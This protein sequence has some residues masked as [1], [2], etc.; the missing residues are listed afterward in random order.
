M[1]LNSLID[2]NE[3]MSEY[4]GMRYDVMMAMGNGF[5]SAVRSR[6]HSQPWYLGGGR[7]AQ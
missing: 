2:V 7:S 3:A 6:S 4:E 5:G 1:T